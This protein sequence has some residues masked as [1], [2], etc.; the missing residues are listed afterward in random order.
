MAAQQKY[1]ILANDLTRRLSN[2]LVDKIS[3]SEIEKKIEQFITGLKSS[4]YSRQ[5]AREIVC[6]GVR[7]WRAKFRKRK[8][9]NQNFYRLAEETKTERLKKKIL[10][11]SWG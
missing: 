10:E 11:T 3:T 5:Q 1:Q 9:A 7:G 8:R 6:S 4:G 2:I